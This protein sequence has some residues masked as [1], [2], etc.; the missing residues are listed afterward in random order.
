MT[1]EEYADIGKFIWQTYVPKSGQSD[2][3]QGE[4]LR[5]SEK[6]RD[7]CHRNGNI[8]WDRGHEILANYILD[9]ITAS[10]DVSD[11]S[12]IQLS[13]DIDRIL[14]YERP[15]TEDDVFDRVERV[16]FD[17]YV[18]NRD[19]IAREINPELKR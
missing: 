5:A 3:V 11:E 7:E 9:T 16:I 4:L 12:K 15:Y 1:D 18:L 8:N 19:P 17:W 2:T 13:Q 6:L 14:D 10:N